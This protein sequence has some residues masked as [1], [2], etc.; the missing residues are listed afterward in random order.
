MKKFSLVIFIAAGLLLSACNSSPKTGGAISDSGS[1]GNSG[2]AD[3][4]QAVQGST[5]GATASGTATSGS[6]TST[7]GN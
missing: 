2:P 7:T 3:T 6:D 5:T 4:T 1:V